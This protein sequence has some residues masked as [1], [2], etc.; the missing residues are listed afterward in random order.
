MATAGRLRDY[1]TKDEVQVLLRAAKHSPRYGP[2]NYAMILLAYRH[3]LRA[4]ELVEL[5]VC[6]VD[7]R[8]GTIYSGRRKGSK[9]SV[10]PME[11]DEIVQWMIVEGEG[12]T[13][14]EDQ[15]DRQTAPYS[16]DSGRVAR[17]RSAEDLCPCP[18]A[19]P[20]VHWAGSCSMARPNLVAH[21]PSHMGRRI[22]GGVLCSRRR[23]M[24]QCH[25]SV[26]S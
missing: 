2:R 23:R 15:R 9:S 4:S 14:Q 19:A 3:G 7:F 16:D 11:R 26:V 25:D 13:P 18:R 10:H 22:S 5:R 1:L 12:R 8:V 24:A 21:L 20:E 17:D 6:D